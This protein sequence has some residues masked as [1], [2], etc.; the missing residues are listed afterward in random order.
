VS[1]KEH[2]PRASLQAFG[3]P[4]HGPQSRAPQAQ[5]VSNGPAFR[6]RAPGGTVRGRTRW[7]KR[8]HKGRSFSRRQASAVALSA[9]VSKAPEARS[10]ARGRRLSRG[11]EPTEPDA[12]LQMPDPPLRGKR[13]CVPANPL[14]SPRRTAV[15]RVRFLSPSPPTLAPPVRWSDR[16]GLLSSTALQPHRPGTHATPERVTKPA[17]GNAKR[18]S[19]IDPH[20]QLR[21]LRIGRHDACLQGFVRWLA[22]KLGTESALLCR[23]YG[24]QFPWANQRSDIRCLMT[25]APSSRHARALAS[26]VSWLPSRLRHNS[27][28]RDRDSGHRVPPYWPRRRRTRDPMFAACGAGLVCDSYNTTSPCRE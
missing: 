16:C 22:R 25:A 13:W 4:R 14:S 5:A 11:S 12:A 1:V 21:E 18:N 26:G 17:A 19:N 3:R 15:L 7:Q 6:R 8:C 24:C 10:L 2:G 28:R 27:F 9:K 20:R 23:N